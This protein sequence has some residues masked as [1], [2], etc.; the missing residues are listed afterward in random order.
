MNPK[1]QE[2]AT[3]LILIN[4]KLI[5]KPPAPERP[6]ATVITLGKKEVGRI[7]ITKDDCHV[8]Y[9]HPLDSGIAEQLAKAAQ[10]VGCLSDAR[11]N[12]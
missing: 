11:E 1:I 3:E 4:P 6:D 5:V 12:D 10:K 9:S 7:A 2:F 8:T